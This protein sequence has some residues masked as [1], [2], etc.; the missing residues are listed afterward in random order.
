[1]RA[2]PLVRIQHHPNRVHLLPE[3]RRT[4]GLPLAVVADPD[5]EGKPSALRCY[6]ECVTRPAVGYTHLVILQDDVT[7]CADFDVAVGRV[8]T[9]YPDRMVALFVAGAPPASARRAVRA[10]AAGAP[11]V[12]LCA[13]DWVPTVALAWPVKDAAEFARYLTR[14]DEEHWADDPIVGGWVRRTRRSVLAT[15]PSIVQ[16]PDVEPSFFKKKAAAGRN[17]YRVAAVWE[18]GW[19]PVSAGWLET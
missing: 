19:S 12:E 1:M 3:L 8:L 9:A 5:P 11:I 13:G 17:R 6:R 14:V 4:I 7:V 18:Q 2:A 15:V 10:S 16:H